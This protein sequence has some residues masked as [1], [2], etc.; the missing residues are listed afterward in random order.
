[1]RI[2]VVSG[3]RH[4]RRE[5]RP[6]V[7][8]TLAAVAG[9]DEVELRHGGQGDRRRDRGVDAIAA[10]LAEQWGWRVTTIPADWDECDHSLPAELGGCPSRRHRKR[11]KYGPGDYCPRAGQRRNQWMVDRRPRADDVV[12]FPADGPVARSRDTWGLYRRAIRAGLHV[13]KPVP[14]EVSSG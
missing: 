3:T 9:D 13:H 4:A 6:I 5:H 11:R 12:T 2:I 7:A 8:D 10:N 14:L 1:M